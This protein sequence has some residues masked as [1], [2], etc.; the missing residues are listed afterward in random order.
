MLTHARIPQKRRQLSLSAFRRAYRELVLQNRF[1]EGREYYAAQQ[2][3]YFRTLQHIARLPLRQGAR[4]L[5][6]GGGQILLLCQALF[7]DEGALAD[8]NEDFA[9]SVTKY[10]SSFFRC[11]L[12][13][14]DLSERDH[15]DLIVLCEVIEHIPIPA[16]LVLEKIRASMKPGGYIV[17]TTPNLYRLRNLVRLAAGARV[18]DTFMYPE[19][20]QSIGHPLEYSKQHLEWQ[21]ERAGLEVVYVNLEQ[22]AN[23][24]A[25]PVTRIAR[26]LARP[27]L[28]RP[29]WRDS[30][31]GLARK[32]M[33][34]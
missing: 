25:T 28:V 32:P 22:L 7:G 18:F 27:F 2:R 26:W 9:E 34:G 1:F 15:F 6:I 17:L 16:Y 19:A 33:A 23:V 29:L 4:V 3:R 11:D 5:E 21:I 12:L 31:V 8:L 24:G 30:L 20:G 14:D 10:G 13:R